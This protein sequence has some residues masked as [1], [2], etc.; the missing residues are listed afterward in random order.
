MAH[1]VWAILRDRHD[2]SA[3]NS[4]S[5]KVSQFQQYFVS[6]VNRSQRKRKSQLKNDLTPPSG[7]N[8]K[9]S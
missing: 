8:S 1:T 5:S 9:K 4:I 2:A 6:R 3:G 7:E